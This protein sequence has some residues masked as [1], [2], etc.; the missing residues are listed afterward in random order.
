MDNRGILDA[1]YSIPPLLPGYEPF[2]S[3]KRRML[4][5]IRDKIHE[6]LN[7][8][9]S[10]LIDNSKYLDDLNTFHSMLDDKSDT[11]ATEPSN[12]ENGVNGYSINAHNDHIPLVNITRNKEDEDLTYK[13]KKPRANC[14]GCGFDS[15]GF[16]V[17]HGK[18]IYCSPKK[19]SERNSNKTHIQ[20]CTS[21]FDLIQKIHDTKLLKSNHDILKQ[22]DSSSEVQVIESTPTITDLYRIPL[23]YFLNTVNHAVETVEDAK[24]GVVQ[25]EA[26]ACES[27]PTSQIGTINS[28]E[29][30]KVEIKEFLRNLKPIYAFR[31]NQKVG[32][33]I[34]GVQ[35]NRH[36]KI[37]Y[38]KMANDP[39]YNRSK[40]S[41]NC[42]GSLRFMYHKESETITIRHAHKH[43]L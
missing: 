12:G 41:A 16:P 36:K 32:T 43:H 35:H 22:S 18:K 21:I 40:L 26:H 5:T 24:E 27:S 11:N 34:C 29:D 10:T 9:D 25:E 33:Y 13:S 3:F 38:D 23:K 19:Q 30:L 1:N 7:N 42:K 15:F 4:E 37:L 39:T 8:P 28:I 31:I 2:P 6:T 20:Y 14:E 17:S